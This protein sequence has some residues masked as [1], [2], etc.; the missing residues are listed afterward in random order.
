MP[1]LTPP[2]TPTARRCLVL[3]VPDSAGWRTAVIGALMEL[4]Y[5]QNWEDGGEDPEDVAAYFAEIVTAER[6]KICMF[7]GL[8]VASASA[9][10]PD[11]FLECDGTQYAA[12]DYPALFAA[13]GYTYGGSGDYFNV[14][15]FRSRAIVGAGQSSGNSNRALGDVGGAEAHT[16][17]SGEMPSHYHTTTAS[18]QLA[19][20]G[21][22]TAVLS[23][24][25]VPPYMMNSN[26]K[27]GDGAHN[28]MQPYGVAK[29]LIVT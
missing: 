15:D 24:L 13:I 12:A 28:N 14:P 4:T 29:W 19:Q 1:F 17:T 9:T 27:G 11:G 10:V 21:A 20:L 6:W 2:S 3:P 8:I 26:S 7:S 22:G 16:L 18:V 23:S 5:S 25:P